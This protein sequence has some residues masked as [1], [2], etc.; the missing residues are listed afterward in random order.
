MAVRT[1]PVGQPATL[2][3]Y[4][5]LLERVTAGRSE[6]A[7]FEALCGLE[8]CLSDLSL[9]A[10]IAGDR[11]DW[12]EAIDRLRERAAAVAHGI[13]VMPGKPATPDPGLLA[14]L[15]PVAEVAAV[16]WSLRECD[17]ERLSEHSVAGPVV[18]E[19]LTGALVDYQRYVDSVRSWH[20]RSRAAESCEAVTTIVGVRSS[21]SY[22]APLWTAALGG[23]SAGVR[24]VTAR[25]FKHRLRDLAAEAVEWPWPEL[26]N[27]ALDGQ[28]VIVVDDVHGTGATMRATLDAVR[29]AASARAPTPVVHEAAP[30]SP[31]PPGLVVLSGVRRR[32]PPAETNDAG[33][34]RRYFEEALA[35]LCPVESPA[36]VRA[37][38]M[39]EGYWSR[40]L[41]AL[42]GGR[43]RMLELSFRGGL[44]RRYQLTCQ[45]GSRERVLVAKYVGFGLP[46]RTHLAPLGSAPAAPL[47]L[48]V[49]DGYLFYEWVAGAPLEF[50]GATPESAFDRRDLDAV[51]AVAVALHRSAT[52][53]LP[54]HR[55]AHW[56]AASTAA[57]RAE[58][59]SAPDAETLLRA[60]GP[61]G[62]PM[63]LA[64]VNHGHWHWIRSP[65]AGLVRVHRE[66]HRMWRAIDPSADLM[67][68]AL[69]LGLTDSQTQQLVLE[70]V[71]RT[72]DHVSAGRLSLGA[73]RHAEFVLSEFDR[74]DRAAARLTGAV[75]IGGR[76][77]A[78][79]DRLAPYARRRA[80]VVTS[81]L[82]LACR[83]LA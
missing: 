12:E 69:E 60:A 14:L 42:T 66:A 11:V 73:L 37:E 29:R 68:A 62:P 4:A 46:A 45:D 26:E 32:V 82:R 18:P 15:P 17:D 35:Q 39:P 25:P 24:Y 8:Q 40:Y 65:R 49:R 2:A 55:L 41:A 31:R 52:R 67:G 38:R 63:V 10:R 75:H 74:Q 83:L 13:W 36:V 30:S 56:A 70:Y 20:E 81:A 6:I 9:L 57:V 7:C 79:S 33:H 76:T 44:A 22:L 71:N 53:R 54:A 48:G 27:G 78:V 58:A 50:Q 43:Q 5:A 77:H 1:T 19:C 47:F 59:G 64:P 51:V 72:G 80:A 21:G 34:V 16:L 3:G 23:R 61:S 28:G